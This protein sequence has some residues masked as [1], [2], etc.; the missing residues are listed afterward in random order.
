M[1]RLPSQPNYT[2]PEMGLRLP[3]SVEQC[4]TFPIVAQYFSAVM[5]K[6]TEVEEAK[7]LMTEAVEWSVMK[8]LREEKTSPQNRR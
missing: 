7:Q 1:G 5:R 2:L 3:N 6:I 4:W 8:W